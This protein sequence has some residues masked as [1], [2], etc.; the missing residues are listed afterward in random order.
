MIDLYSPIINDFNN[1]LLRIET[2]NNCNFNCA[3][4]T[5]S[6]M[7]RPVGY[8]S[9]ELFTK[10]IKEA[11]DLGIV[12]LDIRN[13]GEPLLDKE[14]EQKIEI[15]KH[16]GFTNVFLVTN[17]SLLTNE[18]YHSLS[19]A[20]LDHI[21]VSI[22]PKR[23][24]ELTRKTSFDPIMENLKQISEANSNLSLTIHIFS[25]DVSS[26]KEYLRLA[27]GLTKLGFQWNK[28]FEHNWAEGTEIDLD[29]YQLCQRVWTQFTVF[30]DGLVPLC[31]LDYNGEIILGDLKKDSLS[32]VIN[33]GKYQQ[34][35]LQQLVKL[36][37][38]I[39]QC[40]NNA[41]HRG[42]IISSDGSSSTNDEKK[43]KEDV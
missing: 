33:S 26:N 13:F 10:I 25:S 19:N 32:N 18:R 34:M 7:T 38:R 1:I 23:E 4:C 17:A 42:L 27:Y 40:C 11:S 15:A 22:S 8:M 24:F 41:R 6:K 35:R 43:E 2:T 31:C 29:E 37:P 12:S 28:L 20:G 3:F 5:H 16:F 14:L 39:C 21:V 9:Q 36:P 30:W